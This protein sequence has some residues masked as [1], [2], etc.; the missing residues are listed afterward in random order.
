[1]PESRLT[2][3]GFLC[4]KIPIVIPPCVEVIPITGPFLFRTVHLTPKGVPSPI[5]PTGFDGI[6]PELHLGRYGRWNSRSASATSAPWRSPGSRCPYQKP[7][8][9]RIRMSQYRFRAHGIDEQGA[10]NPAPRPR[11]F[12][13]GVYS[14]AA[15]M[16]V[17]SGRTRFLAGTVN[18]CGP[19]PRRPAFGERDLDF[20]LARPHGGLHK[21]LGSNPCTG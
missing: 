4:C 16:P 8:P 20:A 6:S 9:T 5:E 3:L 12:S 19:D 15:P 18:D 11:E 14:G 10:P 17:S 13:A 2:R 1:M 21:E 7:D